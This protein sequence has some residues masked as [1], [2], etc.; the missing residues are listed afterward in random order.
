MRGKANQSKFMKLVRAPITILSKARDL[1]MKRLFDCASKHGFSGANA[2]C[3]AP[4]VPRN[5]SVGSTNEVV[6]GEEVRELVRVVSKR[7]VAG[8]KVEILK[9]DGLKEEGKP[10]AGA[11]VGRSYSVGLGGL[12]ELMRTSLVNLRKKKVIMFKQMVILGINSCTQEAKPMLLREG[13][14]CI[15]RQ[16]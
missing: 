7:D 9:V 1:Y 16:N 6:H 5:P 3:P 13:T 4:L 2:V 10:T 14:L 8:T 15:N 12:E 11:I